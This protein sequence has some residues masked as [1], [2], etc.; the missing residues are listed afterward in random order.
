MAVYEISLDTIVLCYGLDMRK[1]ASSP[2]RLYATPRIRKALGIAGAP[3][4]ATKEDGHE[5]S[6]HGAG[7]ATTTG[8]E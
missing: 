3:A 4:T 1:Y 7:S 8:A 6:K 5:D 2:T